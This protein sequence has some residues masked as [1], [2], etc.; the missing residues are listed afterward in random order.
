LIMALP[1]V[2]R[3][4]AWRVVRFGAAK[5][6]IALAG[7]GAQGL[8][9]VLDSRG[10]GYGGSPRATVATEPSMHW[11]V[12]SRSGGVRYWMPCQRR[13]PRPVEADR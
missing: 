4:S 3:G 6:S 1:P 9:G 8:G 13:R 5:E 2:I 12:T 7:D 11:P 10:L